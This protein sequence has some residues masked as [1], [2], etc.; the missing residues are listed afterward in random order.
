MLW[1]GWRESGEAA[2]PP[3]EKL[4]PVDSRGSERAGVRWRAVAIALAALAGACGGSTT[5]TTATTPAPITTETLTGTVLAGGVAFHT[6]TVA[7]QGTL[8]A[9]LTSLSPQS[10]ITMGMGIGTV[11]GTACSLLSTNETTKVG[12]VLSGTIAVGSFC[13]Q[14][15]DIGNVQVSDDYVITLSH[16]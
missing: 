7:Q 13:V 5:P 11:S 9:T 2:R 8:T 10:T 14:I 1:K 12:T 6:F 4:M 15:Y 16:P 3:K